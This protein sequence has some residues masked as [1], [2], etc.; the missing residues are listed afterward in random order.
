VLAEKRGCPGNNLLV[1]QASTENERGALSRPV[2]PD[3]VK[4]N[5]SPTAAMMAMVLMP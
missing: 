5:V 1:A 4:V 2:R 3:S